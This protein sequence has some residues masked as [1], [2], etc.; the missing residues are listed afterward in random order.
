MKLDFLYVNK[1]I[2]SPKR[3]TGETFSHKKCMKNK[4][5]VVKVV[6]IVMGLKDSIAID[7]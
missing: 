2:E 4:H 1:R 7:R 6:A 3:L 5:L